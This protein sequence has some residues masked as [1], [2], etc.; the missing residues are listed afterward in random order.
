MGVLVVIVSRAEKRCG[1]QFG[2]RAWNWTADH[3][4]NLMLFTVTAFGAES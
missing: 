1:S 3:R 4:R 2:S